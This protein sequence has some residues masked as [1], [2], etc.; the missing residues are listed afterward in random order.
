LAKYTEAEVFCLPSTDASK[1]RYDSRMI[2]TKKAHILDYIAV[3][4]EDTLGETNYWVGL[5]GRAGS[6]FWES[7]TG[8]NVN[9]VD[10]VWLT[11]GNDGSPGQLCAS[12]P[13]NNGG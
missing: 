8:E 4:M 12:I 10:D 6:A 3:L 5:D 1:G 2:W 13:D 9:I 7:S 11:D